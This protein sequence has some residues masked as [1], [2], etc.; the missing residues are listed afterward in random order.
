MSKIN[1]K[2][3]VAEITKSK[4][5][6]AIPIMTHP[7][8]EMIGRS[9]EEACK[10]GK[11]HSEAIIA[12][13][14]SFDAA[15]STVIMD[16]TVEAE[17]FG[18]EINFTKH[19]VPSVV[20]R[21]LTCYDDVA[22]LEIPSLNKGRLQE[23]ILANKLSAE[24]ITDKPVFAGAIGPYSLAGRLYD[25]TEIMMAIYIEPDT[26]K[27]L[28]DKCT[29]FLINYITALKESGIGGVVIAEPASGLLSGH[30]CA[31][32][33]STYVKKIVDALQDDYFTVILHNCGNT[34]HCTDAMLQSGAAA[35]HFGNKID[36][37]D[38]L[39]K[40]ESNFMVMGNID[41]VGVMQQMSHI[42]VYKETSSLL[43]RCGT[44][45]NFVISTGCDTPPLV[46][47]ENIVAFYKAVS[48]YNNKI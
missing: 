47:K 41:P 34:G 17:A 25:M 29:T 15:A 27:L 42:D 10:S 39:A 44:Y 40:I 38:A 8:I 5:V 11:I 6:A 45:P 37:A 28:L 13:N 46:P 7:G 14:K 35:Y 23:Y 36:M 33:S 32:Y 43:E 2:E 4:K 22:A 1:M 12:L 24:A 19:E 16:L 3:W 30:D 31:T 48:D 26:V 20:G 21:A 9:V 18:A